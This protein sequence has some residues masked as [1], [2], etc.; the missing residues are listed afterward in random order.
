MEI[1]L[2]QSNKK[3]DLKKI[4]L[5]QNIKHSLTINVF[6]STIILALPIAIYSGIYTSILHDINFISFKVF[7]AILLSYFYTIILFSLLLNLLKKFKFVSILLFSLVSIHFYL[8]YVILSNIGY[9]IKLE[10]FQLIIDTGINEFI[11]Q[12]GINKDEVIK[13]SLYALGIFIFSYIFILIIFNYFKNITK[14]FSLLI[15]FIIII[16]DI[17]ISWYKISKDSNS[18]FNNTYYEA[19]IFRPNI[20]K[21]FLDKTKSFTLKNKAKLNTDI[22]CKTIENKPPHIVIF[23]AESLR[24]DMMTKEIMPYLN[25]L[26]G[27]I[28]TNNYSTS[29]ATFFSLFS[30]LYGLFP[31]YYHDT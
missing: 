5:Y 9:S 3:S 26:N 16:L 8:N 31:T 15:I 10:H 11:M 1:Y 14:S 24:A 6:V 17:S 23:V 20:S 29:N 21:Y 28:F 12:S 7:I 13:L 30:V 22:K 27:K 4:S 19:I 18:V 2:E 25:N